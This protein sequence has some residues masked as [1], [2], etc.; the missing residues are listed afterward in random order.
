VR[1]LTTE[2]QRHRE[3]EEG[4]DPRTSPIIGAAIEVH[5][6]LGPGLLESAYEEC[7]CHELRLRGLDFTRQVA[8]PVQYKG[9][10]LDCGYKL[11]V[12]VQDAVILELKAVDR[13][14]PIHE[15]QLLTYLRLTGKNVGLLIK[16][17]VPVL[18]RWIV[19]MVL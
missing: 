16:F 5:R 1:I 12:V 17:N 10:K 15:A 19:R 3:N 2:A 18:A 13:L 8:L 11:D 7:L 14:L 4:R 9:V 6:A